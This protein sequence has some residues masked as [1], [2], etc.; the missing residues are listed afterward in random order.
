MLNRL[1]YCHM[2]DV[3]PFWALMY[4]LDRLDLASVVTLPYDIINAAEQ[5]ERLLRRHPYNFAR[6]ELPGPV[7]EG[8][9]YRRAADELARWC[10]EGV[11]RRQSCP[12]VYP[13][14][15]IFMDRER[16]VSVTRRGV[17]A[18]LAL[19]PW[20]DGWIRPHEMTFAQPRQGRLQ[21]LDATLV[22]LSPVLAMHDGMTAQVERILGAY[23]RSAVLEVTTDDGTLH[24]MWRIVDH[25][26]VSAFSRYMR[27]RRAYVLDGHHRYEAMVEFAAR[28]Q[29]GDSAARHRGLVCL[30]AMDDSGLVILP[31]HRVIHAL[32]HL[33]PV[34]FLG[35]ARRHCRVQVIREGRC[36]VMNLKHVLEQDRHVPACVVMLSGSLDAYLLSLDNSPSIDLEPDSSVFH[37]LVLERILD[38]PPR[39]QEQHVR[40]VSDTQRARDQIAEGSGQLALFVRPPTV[41]QVKQLADMNRRMPQKSTYFFPKLAS[42][43]VMMPV[44]G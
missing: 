15:Q 24:R 27:E 6:I 21:L 17:V 34:E 32:K 33:D 2:L 5:R 11:L 28:Q 22:H 31:T 41:S 8:D 26:V 35:R 4:D 37:K 20:S 23:D 25:S 9:C 39:F 40:Y 12:A 43:L 1:V 7:P 18:A 19:A 29:R 44:D 13:Y 30:V 16:N 10:A 38:M 14:H 42:G 3:T 36:S